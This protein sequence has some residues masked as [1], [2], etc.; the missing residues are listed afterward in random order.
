MKH[1][2]GATLIAASL[3]AAPTVNARQKLTGE[4]QL[5]KLLDGRVAGDPVSC[6]QLSQSQDTQVIDKTALVYRVGR[7][8]YVNRPT[9]ADRL[10]SDDILVTKLYSSQLCR[11]DTVQLH[12]RSTPSMWSGFVG[13]QDF[14]P[15]TKP[16]AASAK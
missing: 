11:L 3:L 12:S 13:L 14:V 8:L 5:A 7:T 10:G 16:K 6:I 4:E 1:V 15:Y 9:N 2:V